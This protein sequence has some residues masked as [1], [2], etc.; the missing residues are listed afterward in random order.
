MHQTVLPVREGKDGWIDLFCPGGVCCTDDGEFFSRMVRVV[1]PHFLPPPPHTHY[2]NFTPTYLNSNVS[3]WLISLFSKSLS[4]DQWWGYS[5]VFS[6]FLNLP[7]PTIQSS[8]RVLHYLFQLC[9]WLIILISFQYPTCQVAKIMKCCVNKKKFLLKLK[10]TMLGPFM[11]LSLRGD[12]TCIEVLWFISNE[13]L[14]NIYSQKPHRLY[15]NCGFYQLDRS[16]QAILFEQLASIL[17]KERLTLNLHQACWQ[18]AA[19]LLWPSQRKRGERIPI[20]ARCLWG[21]KCTAAT[22]TIHRSKKKMAACRFY[23]NAL[24]VSSKNT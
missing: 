17:W 7:L 18:L 22:C 1:S 6:L 9:T 21:I 16:H 14:L 12:K 23:Q 3:T 8:S 20:S 2:S 24:R 10:K 13:L 15:A 19:D 11:L 4:H 5:I